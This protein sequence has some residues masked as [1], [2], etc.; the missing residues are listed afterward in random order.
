MQLMP[1]CYMHP[2][3]TDQTGKHN[4]Q[5]KLNTTISFC[6]SRSN[7]VQ[8]RDHNGNNNLQ[9]IKLETAIYRSNCKTLSLNL[10]IKVQKKSTQ[11]VQLL[12]LYAKNLIHR[13]LQLCLLHANK[14]LQSLQL[15]L[16]HVSNKFT[17]QTGLYSHY[18]YDCS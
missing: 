11:Q 17:N 4:L 9:K 18:S 7:C 10:L 12:L 3:S 2:Q 6:R 14:T 8:S 1:H 13:S 16:L 15:W 5:I